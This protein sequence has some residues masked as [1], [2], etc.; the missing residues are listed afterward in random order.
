MTQPRNC[1]C[2]IV[3]GPGD[4]DYGRTKSPQMPDLLSKVI[5]KNKPRRKITKADMMRWINTRC[6]VCRPGLDHLGKN[7][8]YPKGLCAEDRAAIIAL[9]RRSKGAGA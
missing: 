2:H 5:K 6:M 3:I 9:I 7:C 8:L 1:H 4:N